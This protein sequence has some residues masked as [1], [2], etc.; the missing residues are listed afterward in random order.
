M[1]IDKV[2][3]QQNKSQQ[4]QLTRSGLSTG[5]KQQRFKLWVLKHCDRG[6]ET[7][8]KEE[9]TVNKEFRKPCDAMW[10]VGWLEQE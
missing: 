10:L 9:S 3:Q 5:H 1:P 6:Q 4:A 2:T 8:F 7:E